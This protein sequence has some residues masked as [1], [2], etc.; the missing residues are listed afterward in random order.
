MPVGGKENG[1]LFSAASFPPCP[2]WYF[3][4]RIHEGTKAYLSVI[5]KPKNI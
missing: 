3:Q 5:G 2:G 1:K 4:I